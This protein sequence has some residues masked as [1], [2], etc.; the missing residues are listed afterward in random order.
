[1]SSEA[2]DDYFFKVAWDNE[3]GR[4]VSD[5]FTL[6]NG[7]RKVV[8]KIGGGADWGGI[9]VRSA[10]DD[11]LLCVFTGPTSCPMRDETCD[12]GSDFGG[13]EVY[14]VLEKPCSGSGGW[15]NLVFDDIRIL[16]SA[17]AN[18]RVSEGCATPGPTMYPTP[19]TMS[20]TVFDESNFDEVITVTDENTFRDIEDG[21]A[22]SSVDCLLDGVSGSCYSRTSS[23]G[24]EFEGSG[25]VVGALEFVFD[26]SVTATFVYTRET[27]SGS[28]GQNCAVELLVNDDVVDSVPPGEGDHNSDRTLTQLTLIPGDVVL[29]SEGRIDPAGVTC[30]LHFYQLR[31]S[32]RTTGSP[33]LYPT[34][35]PT[36]TPDARYVRIKAPAD[37]CLN[38]GEVRVYDDDGTLLTGHCA[39]METRTLFAAGNVGWQ[40]GWKSTS[41]PR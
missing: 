1:M 30:G 41:D 4:A 40:T 22:V 28:W 2:L 33:T 15:E 19:P 26:Y 36:V 16:N 35:V 17:N 25:D 13:T 24:W 3:C 39:S 8:S 14:I 10:A 21:F 34:S 5:S 31:I 29:L 20:P 7:A 12:F 11:S 9:W 27:V 37:E 32:H 6:P 23:T 18:L 38:L